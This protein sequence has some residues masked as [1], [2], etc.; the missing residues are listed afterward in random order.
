MMLFPVSSVQMEYLSF[1]KLVKLADFGPKVI[2][3]VAVFAFVLM[4][5]VFM[6]SCKTAQPSLYFQDLPKDTVLHNVVTKDFE[7]KIRKGDII[8]IG[9]S[10]LSTEN[11]AL[12][13]APELTVG[14]ITG[15][16]YIVDQEGNISFPKLGIVQVEGMTREELRNKLLKE[17]SPAYLKEPVI[18][19][20]FINHK[21]TVIGEGH[22]T[23]VTMV[24]ERLTILDALVAGGGIDKGSRKDNVLV[25]RDNG[26]DKQFKRLN[27]NSSSIFNSPFYY[28]R[29]DDI[30]Y[31]EP[32]QEPKKAN[33]QQII[34][35]VT[36]GLSFVF[37][38]LDRLIK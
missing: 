17:L 26:T 10:S 9:I 18:T 16:G 3:K 37:L 2:Q 11:S 22:A 20:N 34:S 19:V 13:M 6:N 5:A 35:Y 7:L 1:I 14:G 27:L 28:L 4:F 21:V 12:F 15:T 30:I 36:A 31:I 29:P 38:V 24:N 8:N 25:I 33:T 23:S 32:K